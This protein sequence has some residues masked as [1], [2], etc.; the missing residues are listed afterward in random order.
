MMKQIQILSILLLCSIQLNSQNSYMQWIGGNRHSL[1]IVRAQRPVE[2]TEIKP[3]S[4]YL[5]P[6]R[7]ANMLID[8]FFFR[9][10]SKDTLVINKIHV[11]N[12]ERYS[13]S[14]KTGPGEIGFVAYLNSLDAHLRGFEHVELRINVMTNF[15]PWEMVYLD[16]ILMGNYLV[17]KIEDIDK[18]TIGYEQV[19]DSN[20]CRR[21]YVDEK[22]V[23]LAMGF[24]L[25]K[26]GK[27]VMNWKFWDN[28]VAIEDTVFLKKLSLYVVGDYE[29][30]PMYFK[31][32]IFKNG[33]WVESVHYRTQASREFYIDKGTDSIML[34]ND[35]FY[36][37]LA[38]N[39]GKMTE[40]QG[41]H[42]VQTL[43]YGQAFYVVQNLMVPVEFEPKKYIVVLNKEEIQ[44]LS[45]EEIKSRYFGLEFEQIRDELWLLTLPSKGRIPDSVYLKKFIMDNKVDYISRL[46]VSGHY[47]R[48]SIYLSRTPISNEIDTFARIAGRY[49]F[50]LDE[51]YVPINGKY[52]IY[53]GKMLDESFLRTF[54]ELGKEALFNDINIVWEKV[55]NRSDWLRPM[56][57]D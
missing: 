1:G 50:V 16:Y 54:N 12:P 13:F 57:K 33:E 38:V 6:L 18:K 36:V 23:P 7:A 29:W 41:Y 4:Y 17:K 35:T 34:Y 48:N 11:S 30:S 9:N 27:K 32:R 55:W 52:F 19:I 56:F 15:S 21:L 45:A 26:E 42:S 22:D 25:K 31:S 46:S 49:G 3:P 14:P 39:Y 10:V 5:R 47:I 43:K 44:S 40:V 53:Q 51:S 28:G 8:T 2:T 37:K 20:L 24:E